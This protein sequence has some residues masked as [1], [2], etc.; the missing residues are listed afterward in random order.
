MEENGSAYA[1]E[2]DPRIE[3]DPTLVIQVSKSNAIVKPGRSFPLWRLRTGDVDTREVGGDQEMEK[4]VR[5]RLCALKAVQ[6]G[7]SMYDR[8]LMRVCRFAATTTPQRRRLR[9]TQARKL[10]LDYILPFGVPP[11]L[12][13][14]SRHGRCRWSGTAYPF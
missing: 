4:I 7:P 2:K 8:L 13:R 3:L 9:Y 5:R 6:T 1:L 12:R 14:A 11:G 10:H